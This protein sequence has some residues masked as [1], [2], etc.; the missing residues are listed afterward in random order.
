MQV[1]Y[2]KTQSLAQVK[3]IRTTVAA[4]KNVL[5]LGSAILRYCLSLGLQIAQSRSY[6]QTLHPKVGTIFILGALGYSLH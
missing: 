1:W 6:L 3:G 2:S 4:S 5:H